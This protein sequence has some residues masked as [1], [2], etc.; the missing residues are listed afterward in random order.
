[1]LTELALDIL[2]AMPHDAWITATELAEKL[3]EPY[4]KVSR[5]LNWLAMYDYVD[6]HYPARIPSKLDRYLL[7]LSS[8]EFLK[9]L[10]K[11]N[12]LQP[13]LYNEEEDETDGEETDIE[14]SGDPD[15]SE[16]GGED[17]VDGEET[18]IE[19]R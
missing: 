4:A 8:I 17:E 11:L 13:V 15:G 6:Y 12:N 3:D 5:T 16:E 1:M 2:Q 18:D 9:E 19:V 7:T 10:E 14:V